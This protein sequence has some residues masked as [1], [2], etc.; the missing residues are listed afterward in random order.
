MELSSY[1]VLI[2]EHIDKKR[3]KQSLVKLWKEKGIFTKYESLMDY[4]DFQCLV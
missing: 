2:H 3:K 4:E 1:E